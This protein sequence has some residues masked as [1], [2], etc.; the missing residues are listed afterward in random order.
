MNDSADRAS[1]DVER[2]QRL[3]QLIASGWSRVALQQDGHDD[4]ERRQQATSCF[5]SVVVLCTC[6]KFAYLVASFFTA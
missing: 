6:K 4:G 2:H 1:S 3:H 5:H